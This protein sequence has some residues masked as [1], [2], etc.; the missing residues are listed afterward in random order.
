MNSES[1]LSRLEIII[2]LKDE[3][4]DIAKISRSPVITAKAWAMIRALDEAVARRANQVEASL[5]DS[6]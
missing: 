4:M 2:W 1:W 3:L 5:K 6:P